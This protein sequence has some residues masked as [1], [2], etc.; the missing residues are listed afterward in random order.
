MYPNF[1]SGCICA[2][3]I[4]FYNELDWQLMIFC[5][6]KTFMKNSRF[7]VMSP[8]KTQTFDFDFLS[9]KDFAKPNAIGIIPHD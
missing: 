7:M 3:I 8:M 6:F 5:I 2:H 4:I 9:F 1:I